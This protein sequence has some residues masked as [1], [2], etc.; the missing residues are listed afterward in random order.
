DISQ[1]RGHQCWIAV[2]ENSFQII[3]YVLC[4]F[5][6]RSGIPWIG[7]QFRLP[8]GLGRSHERLLE[9]A[10]KCACNYNIPVLC[11][12]VS[13]SEENNQRCSTLN[14]IH[15]IAGTIVDPHLGHA[16]TDWPYIPKV[17]E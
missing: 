11:A 8:L 2:L 13:A 1:S 4:G 16:L 10:R 3:R 14:E 12:L 15:A 17:T 5:K 7:F 6:V 9:F